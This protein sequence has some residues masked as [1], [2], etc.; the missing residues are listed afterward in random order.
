[1]KY[2]KNITTAEEI[3]KQFRVYCV[4]MHPDKGGDPEEFKLMMSEYN[5]MIKNFERAKEE[6]RAEEEARQAA[7]EARKEAEERKRK[8]EE[9]ARRAAEALREVIAKWSG[10]LKTVTPAS[11]WIEKPTAEYLAAVKYN[12]KKILNEYFPG[13]NFKVALKNKTWSASAEIFWTDGPTRQQVE[14]VEELN[15]FISHYHTCSPYEDYG[16]DEEMKSTRAWRDQYGQILA[17]RFEFTRTFSD[18]GKAEV[19][20]KIYE[21][22]PQ[23]EGMTKKSA[24]AVISFDDALHLCQLLGFYHKETGKAW[25]DLSEEEREKRRACDNLYEEQRQ[26]IYDLESLRY[27][28]RKTTSLNCVLD[29]FLKVY[30][31]SEETTR[32]A[33]EAAAAPVFEAKHG[34]TWQAIKKALGANVFCVPVDGTCHY[35]KISINEAAELVA[36][37]VSVFLGKPA[38][39]DGEMVNYGVNGGGAKVQQKRADKFAAVGIQIS[40]YMYNSYKDVEIL[41]FAQNVLAELRKDAEEVEKQRKAWEEEQKNGKQTARKAD[42]SQKAAKSEKAAEGVDMTAAPAEGL[43][44]VEIAGGVAVVGDQRTTYKN[45]KQIKAHGATWNKEAQQWQAT[46]AEAVASLRE[47]F[48]MTEQSAAETAQNDAQQDETAETVENTEEA[49][50][51]QQSAADAETCEQV[52]A[53]GVLASALSFLVGAIVSATEKANEALKKAAASAA[54]ATAKFEAEHRAEER[55]EAAAILREQ[56]K[57]VSE[58]VA[59]LSDTLAQMQERLNALESGQDVSEEAAEEPQTDATAKNGAA[60]TQPD[61]ETAQSRPKGGS[62]SGVSLD[63]LRTAAEDVERLTKENRHGDAVL[64]ELYT[65][66]ACGVNVRDIIDEVRGLNTSETL[67]REPAEAIRAKRSE[68]RRSARIRARAVLSDEEFLTLYTWNEGTEAG[69]GKAA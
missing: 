63:M 18:L 11:G 68:F 69:N 15:L 33:A 35:R 23:F 42:R 38:M 59:S 36:K 3:K 20:A 4:S 60:T 32:A 67:G 19:M 10:K 65:L 53:V 29:A 64:S 7:E 27:W 46:T 48:G 54:E 52:E 8:E 24:S 40:C 56:I 61:E 12:I 13:V 34:A 30:T 49:T 1:M 17:D 39:Y 44:L 22:F 6:A 50:E 47:W 26:I 43:E 9:E 55:K 16:H 62:G 14:E 5:D 25:A 51:E 45:R 66:C 37:G 57:K 31:V 2:F 21:V 58:Q 41:Q 28:Y